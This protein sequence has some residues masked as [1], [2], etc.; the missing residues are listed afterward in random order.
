MVDIFNPEVSQVT[1]GI[2]G[3]LILIYGTNSTGK[4]KNLA[5]ADKPLVCCFENGLGAINGVKNVKIKKWTDWTS[6]VKQL[7]SNKTIAEAKKMYSSIIIDTVDGMADLAAEFVCG[8]FGVARINDGNS[9]YGLWKE[10]G[11]EIN[12]YLKLLTNAGYTIFFIA[13]EGERVFQDA[14]GN[15][16]TKIYPRGDKRVIDPICDLCD[17]IGYAQ[18]QPDTEDGEE[19]LSTLYLK[20]SPAYH[21]RSRFVHIV[22]SIPEWNIQKLDQAISDAIVAEEKES[23]IK[24]ATAQETAKKVAKAKKEEIERKVPIE[25][26][27]STIGDKLQKMSAK[28]GDI[29][30]Y[31]DL[32]QDVLGTTDFKASQATESQRQQLEALIDGLVELGY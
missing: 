27:I 24:A 20:G 21:A 11:A 14:Q 29:S 9:G 12:K 17:I 4:T 32:M 1:K 5:K 31:S 8:N 26:L 25:E 7:T 13:H 28:E 15:E 22:K 6:F 10:Y 3:K 2:E 19:V 30:S 16:Y 23:G 18:I